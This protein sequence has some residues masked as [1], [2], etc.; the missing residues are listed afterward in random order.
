MKFLHLKHINLILPLLHA[1]ITYYIIYTMKPN[2]AKWAHYQQHH[3][4]QLVTSTCFCQSRCFNAIRVVKKAKIKLSSEFQVPV[5][6][7]EYPYFG[8]PK[9]ILI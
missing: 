4:S 1:A 5:T 3:L 6:L 7:W 2:T 8:R 9:P